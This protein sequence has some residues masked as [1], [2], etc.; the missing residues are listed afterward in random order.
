[1][2]LLLDPD[3]ALMRGVPTK[4]V[5]AATTTGTAF[6]HAFSIVRNPNADGEVHFVGQGVY[7]QANGNIE[8]T[9]DNGTS[10]QVYQAFDFIA[11]PVMRL[12][13]G[14][15]LAYRFN[16]LAFVGTSITVQAVLA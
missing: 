6:S 3:R 14:S 15:G 9:A 8:V 13:L 4:V 7:S 1:M 11:N 10:W 2:A 5:E 16:L 12:D